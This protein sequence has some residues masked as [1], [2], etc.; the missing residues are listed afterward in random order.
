[1]RTY[2]G[3]DSTIKQNCKP[4]TQVLSADALLLGSCYS[5]FIKLS[6]QESYP[7][8]VQHLVLHVCGT[9]LCFPLSL[10]LPGELS[11]R[12]GP[13]ERPL[14]SVHSLCGWHCPYRGDFIQQTETGGTVEPSPFAALYILLCYQPMCLT[15]HSLEGVLSLSHPWH[16]FALLYISAFCFASIS[17]PG[18]GTAHCTT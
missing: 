9:N 8:I 16:C 15:L 6:F 14:D 10:W 5:A 11:D 2:V 4:I 13:A 1:M 18:R 17:C 12:L 3:D 7:K